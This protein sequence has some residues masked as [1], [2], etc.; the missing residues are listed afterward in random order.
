VEDDSG[1]LGERVEKVVEHSPLT[2][3]CRSLAILCQ[4][5]RCIYNVY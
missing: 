5:V 3:Y 1:R 2:S 4:T